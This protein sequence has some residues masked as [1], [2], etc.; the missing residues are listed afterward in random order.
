M[1]C[2][3]QQTAEAN[4]LQGVSFVILSRNR[5][6]MK[7]CLIFINHYCC[8]LFGYKIHISVRH[9]GKATSYGQHMTGWGDGALIM[10]MEFYA[11]ALWAIPLFQPVLLKGHTSSGSERQADHQQLT[12]TFLQGTW[13]RQ[14]PPG[15]RNSV[16]HCIILSW[17]DFP[18]LY[19]SFS[20]TFFCL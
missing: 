17:D 13:W 15:N 18:I 16:T 6:I 14:R 8:N 1:F 3:M 11:H 19:S 2:F 12:A 7:M 9:W 20:A 5:S 10:E 4:N